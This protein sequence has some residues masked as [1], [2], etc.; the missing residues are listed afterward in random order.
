MNENQALVTVVKTIA[1]PEMQQQIQTLLPKDVPLDRF[2][3]VVQMAIRQ[4]PE[5]L[6]ADRQTLYDACLSLARRGLVP[7]K[8]EAALVIFSTK[9]KT[10]NGE[11]WVKKAQ[12]MP[13]VE[14]IIKELAKA[15][16]KAYAVSVYEKDHIE[17]W[18]D[19]DGQHVKHRPVM[20]GDRGQ[21]IGCYAAGKMTDGRTYVEAMSL[22]DIAKVRSRSK[23][24]DSQ[25]NPTG[26]WKSD[27]ER[28]EQK[29]AL[30]RLRKRMP[31][32]HLDM[33]DDEPE[34]VFNQPPTGEGQAKASEFTHTEVGIDGKGSYTQKTGEE[35]RRP[36]ALQSVVDQAREPQVPE[37]PTT[38]NPPEYGNDEFEGEDIV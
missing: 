36:R 2:T 5:I 17:L 16:I 29:S 38:P 15:G 13:M 8:K 9:E 22:E 19:D 7:D 33:D 14:G 34:I 23:Q 37:V 35:K 24:K 25:G 10:P 1:S 30:H 26:T 3:E 11:I 21:R 20:F 12:A 6:K 4:D 18:N 31:I 32:E 27:P 28:M